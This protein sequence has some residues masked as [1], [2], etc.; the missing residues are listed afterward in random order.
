VL[1]ALVSHGRMHGYGITLRIEQ[2][3]ENVL[4]LE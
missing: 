2:I 3:S 1:K 4:R